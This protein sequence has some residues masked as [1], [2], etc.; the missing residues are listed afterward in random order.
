MNPSPFITEMIGIRAWFK[1]HKGTLS[2]A[3]CGTKEAIEFHHI[4][5]KKMKIAA[6]VRV[7]RSIEVIEQELVQCIPLCRKCH[8]VEHSRIKEGHHD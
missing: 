6:L 4:G 8:K 5:K 1:R 7:A 3:H 2:C